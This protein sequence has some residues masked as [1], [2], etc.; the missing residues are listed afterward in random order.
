MLFVK[1]K[2][3]GRKR[4]NAEAIR[5]ELRDL[6]RSGYPANLMTLRTAS[7]RVPLCA[8]DEKREFEVK[9]DGDNTRVTIKVT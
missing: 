2:G 9:L 8:D 3:R 6:S 4:R 7:A 1:I 5:E